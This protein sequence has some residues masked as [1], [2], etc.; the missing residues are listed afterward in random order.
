MSLLGNEPT[1]ETTS[2]VDMLVGEGK[3]FKTV[4]DALRGK[5]EADNY[6]E[7]LKLETEKLKEELAKQ[8]HA[9]ELLKKLEA[10]KQDSEGEPNPAA[11]NTNVPD[12]KNQTEE[13]DIKALVESVL[14]ERD[15]RTKAEK[16]IAAVNEALLSVY[17]DGEKAK[18]AIKDKASELGVSTEF[19]ES[20]A[21]SSA[22]AFLTLIGVN[23]KEGGSVR[24]EGSA[25]KTDAFQS[26]SNARDWVYYQELRKSNPAMYRKSEVQ[27]QMIQDRIEM[28]DKAF[29]R[30]G[31]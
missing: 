8:N 20:T 1:T 18:K 28:G 7:Q 30:K 17:G 23:K 25:V 3:K 4:E 12:V 15:T 31:A 29:Y 21:A 22:M 14:N 11:P 13:T 24:Y 5:M 9:A 27:N 19:L 6:I 10:G 26:R 2:V 16:N